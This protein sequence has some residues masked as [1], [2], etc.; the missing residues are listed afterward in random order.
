MFFLSLR[1]FL[2]QVGTQRESYPGVTP[3]LLA[4]LLN[5]K[6]CIGFTVENEPLLMLRL[7]SNSQYG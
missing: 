5:A 2:L 7:M 6:R 4:Q 3:D 1:L